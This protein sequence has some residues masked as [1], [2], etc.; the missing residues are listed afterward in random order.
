MDDHVRRCQ[1]HPFR[2]FQ[3]PS[4]T[5][6]TDLLSAVKDDPRYLPILPTLFADAPNFFPHL[7][8]PDL[9]VP[10]FYEML[11]LEEMYAPELRRCWYSSLFVFLQDVC[12]HTDDLA[13]VNSAIQVD[14]PGIG[15]FIPFILR[16]NEGNNP[17]TGNGLRNA[18]AAEEAHTLVSSTGLDVGFWFTS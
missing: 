10:M 14:P 8:G 11:A 5:D 13:V 18:E 15:P 9:A 1:Y 2:H 16:P 3:P 6:S 4:L 7:E 17:L 12:D